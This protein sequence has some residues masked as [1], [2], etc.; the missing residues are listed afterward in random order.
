MVALRLAVDVVI[1]RVVVAVAA[2][3]LVDVEPRVRGAF[4]R[5]HFAVAVAVIVP[6]VVRAVRGRT[7]IRTRLVLPRATTEVD[8][9]PAVPAVDRA[10]HAP[11]VL[12]VRLHAGITLVVV[13]PG[14]RPRGV[15]RGGRVPPGVRAVGGVVD[16]V[17]GV[18]PVRVGAAGHGGES[19]RDDEKELVHCRSPVPIVSGSG[20][21]EDT[22]EASHSRHPLAPACNSDV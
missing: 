18:L 13:A 2:A 19:D 7:A 16:H 21:T 8:Q 3:Q 6:V 1:V 15:L 20:G 12:E 11:T 22:E 17:V 9:R 10:V 4:A 14:G 5:G